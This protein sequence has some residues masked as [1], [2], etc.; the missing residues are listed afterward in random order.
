MFPLRLSRDLAPARLDA[1]V[2]IAG[3]YFG[4]ALIGTHP[5]AD[6]SVAARVDGSPLDRLAVIAMFA[7]A[8]AVLWARRRASLAAMLA[9]PG[10]LA[11]SAIVV[12][13]L[14]WSDYPDLTL[15]RVMLYLF[16][17]VAGAATAISAGDPRRLH[18]ALFLV[19]SIV[20]VVNLLA[21]VA[22]PGVAITD[23]GVRGVYTQKN[24]AGG[25]AMIGCILGAF[26]IA[27]QDSARERRRGLLALAPLAL[28]LIVTR[29]KTS[30]GLAIL[31]PAVG[32]VA[33]FAARGRRTALLALA[34]L[35]FAFVAAAAMFAASG[36]D[37]DRALD[38]LIGDSSF[39]GRAELW[40][41]ARA[42]IAKHPWFGHGYGAF[43]DVGPI[44][45][46][47]AKLEPGTWL[48]DSEVGLINQAHNGYLDLALNI[49]IPATALAGL[50]VFAAMIGEL[51]RAHAPRLDRPSRAAHGAFAALLLAFL[52]HNTTEATLF[53]RGA[54]FWA[55]IV[56][57]MLA[58]RARGP[59][60]AV[61]DHGRLRP[62][63]PATSAFQD[64]P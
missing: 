57:V 9:H 33:W 15:R 16:L 41:F 61:A 49:G 14:L 51:V 25:V 22:S 47:I 37:T 7:V 29:S 6:T 62:A 31:A 26:W 8:L 43:W 4:Y 28:F 1:F 52:L 3:L 19:F 5:L 44:N 48:G 39:T 11:V 21:T 42:E 34:G 59:V 46:P 35:I 32:A 54:P 23:I 24:V 30:L 63:T 40:A 45:D 20:A 36:F 60:A 18:G 2:A 64:P 12:A 55:T 17:A 38:L 13:S 58:P 10:F 53:L 50:T 27:G 56:V